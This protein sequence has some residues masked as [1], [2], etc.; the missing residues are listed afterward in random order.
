MRRVPWLRSW[1][2]VRRWLHLTSSSRESKLLNVTDY[3]YFL[4]EFP[5]KKF[6]L[7]IAINR[8]EVNQWRPFGT[9]CNARDS[10]CSMAYSSRHRHSSTR[11]PVQVCVHLDK[12]GSEVRLSACAS[13][14]LATIYRD[15][16]EFIRWLQARFKLGHDHFVPR[17][18]SKEVL[19]VFPVLDSSNA[20]PPSPPARPT[21]CFY[22]A[23]LS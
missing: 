14:A 21:N 7:W 5:L 9:L 22:D 19:C 3:F 10:R 13:T 8:L 16:T 2:C 23:I 6:P 20:A 15:F 12:A 18:Y 11:V 1:T 4:I 17:L